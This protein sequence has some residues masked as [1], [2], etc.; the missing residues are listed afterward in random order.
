[1][2]T[3]LFSNLDINHFSNLIVYISG[4]VFIFSLFFPVQLVNQRTVQYLSFMYI[5]VGV[6]QRIFLVFLDRFQSNKALHGV[7]IHKKDSAIIN[8]IY[9]IVLITSLLLPLII[10]DLFLAHH[11]NI[12]NCLGNLISSI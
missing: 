3:N 12:L 6:G 8:Q 2:N 4:I 5:L 9:L 10:F 1:M 7:L 11:S